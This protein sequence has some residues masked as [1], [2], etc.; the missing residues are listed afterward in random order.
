[1]LND[2]S[3]LHESPACFW[4]LAEN[5]NCNL[6][7]QSKDVVW[8]GSLESLHFSD[9]TLWGLCSSSSL[10]GLMWFCGFI[11][12]VKTTVSSCIFF[13]FYFLKG[14][15]ICPIN[16]WTKTVLLRVHIV[17]VFMPTSD[18]VT[19]FREGYASFGIWLK[20]DF[21]RCPL[22]HTMKIGGSRGS[23]RCSFLISGK[24]TDTAQIT[25]L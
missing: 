19:N 4:S 5:V 13:I 8:K 9:G 21:Q 23:K 10:S 16:V 25:V 1:M 17:P 7:R 14:I 6:S 12:S 24:F 20:G 11:Y 3:K 22:A 18:V 2:L 15:Q